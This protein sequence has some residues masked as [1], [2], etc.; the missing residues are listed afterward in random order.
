[1]TTDSVITI[2]NRHLSNDRREILTPT[3]IRYVT[4]YQ[5]KGAVGAPDTSDANTYKVRIP[6]DAD[7][8]GKTYLDAIPYRNL[9]ADKTKDYW[10]IQNGDIVVRGA[11]EKQITNKKELAS[12][13]LNLF[14]VTN[15]SDDTIRGSSFMKHW[16]IGGM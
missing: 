16:R 12:E 9:A 3:V 5:S 6:Y 8:S 11:C 7:Q 14:V 4:W 2:Y 1:M 15:Y 13:G 10:T